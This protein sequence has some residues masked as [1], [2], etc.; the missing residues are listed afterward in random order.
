MVEN[1]DRAKQATQAQSQAISERTPIEGK[2]LGFQ[3]NYCKNILL[4]NGTVVA[5]PNFVNTFNED[6]AG[7]YGGST[8]PGLNRQTVQVDSDNDNDDNNDNN[9][10]NDK[11]E[12]VEEEPGEDEKTYCD[13]PNPS[14]DCFDR[15]DYS[16]TTGL[17][18]CLD[19][20]QVEDW[21]DCE[22][23]GTDEDALMEEC[24]EEDDYCDTSEGCHFQTVDCIDDVN[25]GDDGGDESGGDDDGGGDE[26]E[27]YNNDGVVN[28]YDEYDKADDED[29]K[30]YGKDSEEGG[31]ANCGGESCTATEKEDSWT[32]EDN[33][34]NDEDEEDTIFEDEEEGAGAEEDYPE[35]DVDDTEVEPGYTYDG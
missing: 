18:G 25:K 3:N 10:D 35:E 24:Q 21:K 13:V 5:N 33:S 30:F 32:D 34:N 12:D 2:C 1:P 9:N 23:G 28:K 16:E 26:G 11:D 6:N 22:G 8:E 20:S 19:G 15:L 31:E 27:D 7:P 29:N 17:Y 14:K 4:T